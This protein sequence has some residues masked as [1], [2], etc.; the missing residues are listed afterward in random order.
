MTT[1]D[2]LHLLLK[3]LNFFSIP[4]DNGYKI[5]EI[6]KPKIT[7]LKNSNIKGVV[8][9]TTKIKNIQ[10][11]ILKKSFLGNIKSLLN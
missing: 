11:N 6:I 9:Y 7:G 3:N 4:L 10:D 5:N 2:K 8:K 1:K